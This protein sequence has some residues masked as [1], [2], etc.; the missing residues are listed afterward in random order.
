[1]KDNSPSNSSKV[2]FIVLGI[3]IG[4]ITVIVVLAYGCYK[5]KRPIKPKELR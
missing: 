3:V 2:L 4:L 1:M 5:S